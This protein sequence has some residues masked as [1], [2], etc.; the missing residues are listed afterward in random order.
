[1]CVLAST[2]GLMRSETGAVL[3][4]ADGAR[5]QQLQF[6]L[7]FD[8]EAEDAGRE[9]EIHLARRLADAGEQ[10][11]FRRN[12]GGQRAPHLAF[13]NHVG[14]GAELCQH[15]QH[16]L[17]GIRLHGVADQRVESG[18]GLARRRCSGAS[19]SPSNSSRTACRP[20]PR[21]RRPARPRHAARRRDSRNGSLIGHSG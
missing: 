12:A 7:G 4:S 11:L 9:R 2:S 3:P 21:C 13:R 17:V 20:P 6:R 19:A 1:M 8:V 14:A 10:D 16:G 15:R 18:E 5:R